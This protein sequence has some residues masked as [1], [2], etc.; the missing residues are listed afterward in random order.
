MKAYVQTKICTHT[1][2]AALLYN[3]KLDT[4]SPA[5]PKALLNVLAIVSVTCPRN[6]SL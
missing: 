3:P 6:T 4:D 1:F 5:F 2:V